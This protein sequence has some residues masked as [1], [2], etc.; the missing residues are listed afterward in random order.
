MQT[1]TL[2]K[3]APRRRRV[4]VTEFGVFAAATGVAVLHALDDAFLGRQPGVSLSQHA[5]AALLAVAGAAAAVVAFPRVRPA[6]RALIA[7]SLGGLAAVNGAMHV[8]HIDVDGVAHSDLT[9]VLAFAAGLTLAGLAVT[10]LW[11][12]RRPG[13][14]RVWGQRVLAAIGTFLAVFL[15]LG[16]MS[17]GIIEV[18][19]WRDPIGAAPGPEYREVAFDSSDGLRLT[20]WYR[21]TQNGATVLLVH[22]GNGDRQGPSR[23]ARM[24]VRHGYGV[25]LYDSRGRGDS[26]GSPNSFGWEWRKDVAG[27]L[28]F[29]KAQPEV[30]P[31]RI[32][33]LGLSTGADVLVEVAPD[34]SDL[35]AIVADGAAAETWEDWHRL[36]GNDAGMIPGFLMFGTIRVL[37]G[38]PPSPTLED[39]V[40]EIRQPTLLVSSG[41]AEEYQFNVMYDHVGN[42]NVEHWNL[43]DVGHT[44]AIR[45]AAK[46]YEAR[47]TAFFDREL[48]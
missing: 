38:D 10:I 14:W 29:L 33:G 17:L 46:P 27:A 16:P 25:L 8:K 1:I 39:R 34:R 5:L 4:R 2:E 43:P 23:H 20:G 15:V 9:G 35:R 13:S 7:F 26:E 48:R 31:R 22:G 19:K 28:D 30:D 21:P 40:R 47:V 32:G 6:L 44:A 18:H 24:L 37:S 11:I 45:Q 42:P 36:R 41:T 3:P 12:H